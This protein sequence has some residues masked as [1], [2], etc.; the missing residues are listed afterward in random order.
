MYAGGLVAQTIVRADTPRL[1]YDVLGLTQSYF[2]SDY[3]P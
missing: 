2:E 1:K 3:Q